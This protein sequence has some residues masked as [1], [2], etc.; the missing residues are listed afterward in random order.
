[1]NLRMQNKKC[2]HT[3]FL[4]LAIALFVLVIGCNCSGS[5][6]GSPNI[7]NSTGADNK[8]E[9]ILNPMLKSEITSFINSVDSV[10]GSKQLQ[11]VFLVNFYQEDTICKVDIRTNYFYNLEGFEGYLNLNGYM[12]AFYGVSNECARNLVNLG[13]LQKQVT[14]DNF[15]SENECI[16]RPYEAQVRKYVIRNE[17]L[18]CFF[19]G[20]E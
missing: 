8:Y 10:K 18:S 3:I 12:V 5:K 17:E 7:T 4:R 20:E 19:I 13:L 2:H 9:S 6:K 16:F 11:N 1:M 14:E 15:K